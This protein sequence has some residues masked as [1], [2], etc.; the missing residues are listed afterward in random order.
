M[1]RAVAHQRVCRLKKG[2]AVLIL[3]WG[4]MVGG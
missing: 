4:V 1:H 3:S 2:I